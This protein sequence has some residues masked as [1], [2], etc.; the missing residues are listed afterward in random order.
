M[1]GR[2]GKVNVGGMGWRGDEHH[3]GK[4][5]RRGGNVRARRS[6]FAREGGARGREGGVRGGGEATARTSAVVALRHLDPF[7]GVWIETWKKG[8][9]AVAV[10]PASTEACRVR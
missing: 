5:E 8:G 3:A 1:G 4:G 10:L 9:T 2:V 7:E 6:S